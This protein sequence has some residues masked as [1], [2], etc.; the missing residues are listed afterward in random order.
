MRKFIRIGID[1][2]KNYFQVHA[3]ESEDRKATTRKLSR[4]AMRK[5]FSETDPCLVVWKRALHRII[6]RAN[7]WRWATTCD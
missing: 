5:F 1:L 7:F 6:G 4:L 3:L 2:G